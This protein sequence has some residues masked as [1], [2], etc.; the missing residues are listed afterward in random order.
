MNGAPPLGRVR[1]VLSRPSHPGNI[2]AAARAMKT[3]G[4]SRLV[5]VQPEDF[6]SPVA[7]A[8][9]SGAADL[10]DGARVCGSLEEALEGTVLAVAMTA[11][12]RELSAP[13]L[14]ARDAAAELAAASTGGDVALV[15]GNETAGLSNDE[16]ALCQRPA[17]IP[18]SAEYGSLNLGAAVQI[19]CY[20]LRLA[21]A[22]PGAPPAVAGAGEPAAHEEVER[23][24]DHFERALTASGFHD[25]RQ[26]KRLMPRLRRLFA[27]A[28]LEKEEVSILRGV[29]TSL[30]KK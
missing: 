5:L 12:R 1:I 3:M 9:A 6:P 25:P 23:L 30:E 28:R 19:M 24:I 2:G 21:M 26:P 29:L 7:V 22:D 16:V 27:R 17:M 10:L 11:R 18:V 13:P 20:E 8:R 4:I 15:F 14:W